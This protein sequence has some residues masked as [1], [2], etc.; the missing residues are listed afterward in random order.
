MN[1]KKLIGKMALRS[2][3]VVVYGGNYNY[4]YTTKPIK[5][6]TATESH[7]VAEYNW[8]GKPEVEIINCMYCD[9]NWIEYDHLMLMASKHTEMELLISKSKSYT[10]IKR[11]FDYFHSKCYSIRRKRDG[12]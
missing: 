9:E 8:Y 6:L 3:P 11:L 4:A 1:A 5:I 12:N 7:I 2:A 10:I